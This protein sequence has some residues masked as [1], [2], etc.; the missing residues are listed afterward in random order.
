M[1][2]D[3]RTDRYCWR[4]PWRRRR[5]PSSSGAKRQ[6]RSRSWRK[7]RHWSAENAEK[8]RPPPRWFVHLWQ[9]LLRADCAAEVLRRME[10]E[11]KRPG[12]KAGVPEELVRV[13][14]LHRLGR[15][16]EARAT[17]LRDGDAGRPEEAGAVELGGRVGACGNYSARSNS[18]WPRTEGPAA[19]QRVVGT[20][21]LPGAANRVVLCCTTTG[22]LRLLLF[23]ST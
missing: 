7:Q 19:P 3:C 10:E 12:W 23:N 21:R 17:L 15:K 2:G 14:A 20:G 18:G 4:R 13:L 8:D 11:A 9:T 1:P 5:S 6:R 22:S 16:G